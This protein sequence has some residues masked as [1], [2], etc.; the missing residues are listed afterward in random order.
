M[1]I[2]DRVCSWVLDEPGFTTIYGSLANSRQ[3]ARSGLEVECENQ[4][5]T[6]QIR[7]TCQYDI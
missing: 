1:I 3:R 6:V 4:F 2:R 7:F 5:T